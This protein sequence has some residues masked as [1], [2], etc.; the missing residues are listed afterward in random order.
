MPRIRNLSAHA[1]TWWRCGAKRS[2]DAKMKSSRQLIS[3][4]YIAINETCAL[5]FLHLLESTKHEPNLPT[6]STT[7]ITG[8]MFENNVDPCHLFRR[9][10]IPNYIQGIHTHAAY[11]ALFCIFEKKS[12]TLCLRSLKG[13]FW[14]TH[15]TLTMGRVCTRKFS[16]Y[17]LLGWMGGSRLR[18]REQREMEVLG[19]WVEGFGGKRMGDLKGYLLH[20]IHIRIIYIRFELQIEDWP[21]SF[22]EREQNRFLNGAR[23]KHWGSTEE[24]L[25][26]HWGSMVSGSMRRRA[27]TGRVACIIVKQRRVSLATWAQ[28]RLPSA[29]LMSQQYTFHA[30]MNDS[31]KVLALPASV[32]NGAGKK[33]GSCGV[34]RHRGRVSYTSWLKGEAKV[35]G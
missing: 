7:K 26:K 32:R 11:R 14:R 22:G 20:C 28:R 19:M 30:G 25:E 18:A 29:Q 4:R 13:G 16:L 8:I 23:E 35:A 9:Y 17:M 15:S 3:K 10:V 33:A 27:W 24:A 1:N 5:Q 12:E 34:H 21:F 2:N 31:G 6:S